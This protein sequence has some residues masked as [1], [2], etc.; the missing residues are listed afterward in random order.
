MW[1]ST[2]ISFG[3]SVTLSACAYASASALEVVGIVNVRHVPTI[4]R[5]PRGHVFVEGEIGVAFDG[6]VVVVV[7]PA[8]IRELQVTG[9]RR[10]FARRSLPSCRR[11]RRSRRCCS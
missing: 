4:G 1:L 5:E 11:R 8:E 10:G 3:R 9:E 7:D 6:D 2:M